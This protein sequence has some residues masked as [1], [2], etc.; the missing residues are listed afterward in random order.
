MV[1]WQ[2]GITIPGNGRVRDLTTLIEPP[3]QSCLLRWSEKIAYFVL[4]RN[5]IPFDPQSEMQPIEPQSQAKGS[6]N[7]NLTEA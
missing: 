3:E 6:L 5:P 4:A 2:K 7:V 1:I